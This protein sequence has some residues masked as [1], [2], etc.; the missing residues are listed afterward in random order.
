VVSFTSRPPYSRGKI[1][2]YNLNRRLGGPQS[3]S[4]HGG[5]GKKSH[6][7]PGVEPRSSTA[8]NFQTGHTSDVGCYCG[9]N[10][11]DRIEE[12][13]TLNLNRVTTITCF[14]WFFLRLSRRPTD[15]SLKTGFRNHVSNSCHNHHFTSSFDSLQRM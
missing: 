11:V 10:A 8:H 15:E 1:P 14:P 12:V 4:G 13:L 3:R 9:G 5:E 2:R 7:L 6:Q